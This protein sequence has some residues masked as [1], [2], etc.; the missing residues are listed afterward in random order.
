MN[1]GNNKKIKV[2]NKTIVRN[3]FKALSMRDKIKDKMLFEFVADANSV[4]LQNEGSTNEHERWEATY[5]TDLS[6]QGLITDVNNVSISGGSTVNMLKTNGV[7]GAIK[8]VELGN[9]LNTKDGYFHLNGQSG[10]KITFNMSNN[11]YDVSQIIY[12]MW[13]EPSGVRDGSF[14]VLSNSHV[15][16]DTSTTYEYKTITL[17]SESGN[18]I[19][20]CNNHIVYTSSQQSYT[21][22]PQITSGETGVNYHLF[23]HMNPQSNRLTVYDSS[24]NSMKNIC[25]TS[26]IRIQ[27]EC[28][29]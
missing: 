2:A 23:A 8:G 17:N 10:D 24:T 13:M 4:S 21:T 3:N 29:H 22:Q 9:N 20:L 7:Y 28:I 5:S 1:L 6:N 12:E 16:V 14:V 18:L 26:R 27:T 19:D 15:D 25:I 11:D